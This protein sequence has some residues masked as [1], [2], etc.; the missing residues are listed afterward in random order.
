MKTTN[1]VLPV[2]LVSVAL[3]VGISARNTPQQEVIAKINAYR[4]T[5]K[6]QALVSDDVLNKSAQLYAD[7]LSKTDKTG[8]TV[9]MT[10]P[11][12]KTCK[13]FEE[14]TGIAAIELAG[15]DLKKNY[16]F[17]YVNTAAIKAKAPERFWVNLKLGE[18]LAYG[19]ATPDAAVEGWKK[20]VQGHNENMLDPSW[21]HIGVGISKRP[22]GGFNWVVVFGTPNPDAKAMIALDG[23]FEGKPMP[24]KFQYYT[25]YVKKP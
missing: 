12:G 14:R 13:T 11:N 7:V 19:Q 3:P 21:T 18:I 8:H 25:K 24:E 15:G 20:S 23:T 9:E 6:A 5:K 2:L 17:S 10:T 1:L 22:S 16:Q 4:A